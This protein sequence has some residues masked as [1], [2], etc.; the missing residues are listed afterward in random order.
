MRNCR[1]ARFHVDWPT[2]DFLRRRSGAEERR[3]GEGRGQADALEAAFH[4]NFPFIGRYVLW[5]LWRVSPSRRDP[6]SDA[7]RQAR[8]IFRAALIRKSL[9]VE[10]LN[11][12]GHNCRS[13]GFTHRSS[14]VRAESRTLF[15]RQG[16]PG[17]SSGNYRH[18]VS[19]ILL[20]DN[21][22][23]SSPLNGPNR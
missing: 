8:S 5:L 20:R 9:I 21:Y 12:L 15:L 17:S 1:A 22:G 19:R 10:A 18:Q 4:S 6:A 16:S 23:A 14:S 13:G 3:E 2:G 7:A 11:C